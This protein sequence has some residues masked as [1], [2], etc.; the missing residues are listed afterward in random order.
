MLWKQA[1]NRSFKDCSTPANVTS[2]ENTETRIA[3]VLF[4]YKQEDKTDPN[5]ILVSTTFPEGLGKPEVV[6]GKV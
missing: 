6:E 4:L 1:P 3:S 5:H 2:G